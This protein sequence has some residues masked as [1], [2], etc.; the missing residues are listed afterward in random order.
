MDETVLLTRISQQLTFTT[1]TVNVTTGVHVFKWKYSKDFSVSYGDDG[2]F[3]RLVEVTGT[4]FADTA[5]TPCSAGAFANK[6]GS[7]TCSLCPGG[8]SS[9][10][11]GARQ[12]TPCR[13]NEYSFPGASRCYPSPPC[14]QADVI[15]YYSGCF[16]NQTRAQYYY[17]QTPQ[18]CSENL[19]GAYRKPADRY[20]L[21]CAPCAPGTQRNEQNGQ[22]ESCPTNTYS[23][24]NNQ[25]CEPCPTGHAGRRDF[26]WNN[27]D[28][29]PPASVPASMACTGDC[30]TN[31][32]RL[33]GK[34]YIDSGINHGAYALSSFSLD[35]NVVNDGYVQFNF[36]FAC[37]RLCYLGLVDQDITGSNA[38]DPVLITTMPLQSFLLH[39]G[40]HT[41]QLRIS[42]GSHRFSWVFS[43]YDGTYASL[44]DHVKIYSIQ[45][46]S[47]VPAQGGA[48]N[49]QAC[50]AGTFVT[51]NEPICQPTPPGTYSGPLA[52]QPVACPANTFAEHAGSEGCLPCGAGTTSA[53]GSSWCDE[54]CRFR[55]NDDISYDLKPLSRTGGDMYGPIAGSTNRR[56]YYLNVCSRDHSNAT[57]LDEDRKPLSTQS[58]VNDDLG[59]G[60]D[61]GR[62]TN[63]YPHPTKPDQ[64]LTIVYRNS[65][66]D[67]HS[68]CYPTGSGMFG[69][70]VPR[71]TNITFTCDSVA[72]YGAPQFVSSDG[73][74]TYF[75]WSTL[76][77][78]PACDDS[79]WDF[80][81]TECIDG[82]QMKTYKWKDNPRK[83]HSGQSLPPPEERTC[84]VDTQIPCPAGTYLL[85][86]CVACPNGTWSLG[87]AK[88]LNTWPHGAVPDASIF[89]IEPAGSNTYVT[90]EDTYLQIKLPYDA[91]ST[92]VSL[93]MTFNFVE[94]SGAEVRLSL[95][96]VAEHGYLAYLVVDEQ[97]SSILSTNPAA[98]EIRI[99][100]KTVGTHTIRLTLHKLSYVSS[101]SIGWIRIFKVYAIGTSKAASLCTDALPGTFVSSPAQEPENCPVNTYQPLARQTS[102]LAVPAGR[103]APPGS[104]AHYESLSCH[105]QDFQQVIKGGG[106]VTDGPDSQKGRM[107]VELRPIPGSRCHNPPNWPTEIS[108]PCA[109]PPGS[110]RG[111]NGLCQT[112]SE[113]RP[114]SST[115]NSCEAPTAGTAGYGTWSLLQGRTSLPPPVTPSNVKKNAVLAQIYTAM[116]NKEAATELFRADYT[117][118]IFNSLTLSENDKR[119]IS[120][121]ASS[122]R[123]AADAEADW[124]TV[125][126]GACQRPWTFSFFPEDRIIQTGSI[127][128]SGLSVGSSISVLSVTIPMSSSG[129]QLDVSYMK[130]GGRNTQFIILVDGVAVHSDKAD[131]S[132]PTLEFMLSGA[133][134]HEI[135]FVLVANEGTISNSVIR[136][137][138]LTVYGAGIGGRTLLSCPAG[139][140]SA[141]GSNAQCT[142]CAVGTAAES[143][144][145]AQCK[146]CEDGSFAAF[147]ASS[148]CSKCALDTSHPTSGA[149]HGLC[150]PLCTFTSK[151]GSEHYDWNDLL[152][153]AV[154]LTEG[155]VLGKFPELGVNPCAATST[156]YG[157]LGTIGMEN[158]AFICGNDPYA[159]T[160]TA[161]PSATRTLRSLDNYVNASSMDQVMSQTL[162][163]DGRV[164]QMNYGTSL[165]SVSRE[166]AGI[167]LLTY[168]DG[169][170]CPTGARRTTELKLKCPTATQTSQ[171]NPT[172]TYFDFCRVSM[173]WI[174]NS[175]CK[176]CTIDS[177]RKVLGECRSR[178]QSVIYV[179]KEGERCHH[180]SHIQPPSTTQP[181]SSIHISIGFV[182]AGVICLAL[183][184][185]SVAV[186][187]LRHKK[188]STEYRLLKA[189]HDGT[190][191]DNETQFGLEDDEDGVTLDR[192]EEDD[193][194][195]LRLPTAKTLDNPN[196]DL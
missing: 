191:A 96:N 66:S 22:C 100:I 58:C 184:V 144:R 133:P 182:V 165:K 9:E 87:G 176:A 161:S 151:D 11:P 193:D 21:A 12:C 145:S 74:T 126:H 118:E 78:C 52:T 55:L 128:E 3:L 36:A 103:W 98:H 156:R 164:A 101:T 43:K 194:D 2:A 181:C 14:Q 119:S 123:S 139:Y 41:R 195:G 152:P 15:T 92:P 4:S 1:F 99:P 104:K 53:A 91:F 158:Q 131:S 61:L 142:P 31:G 29:L 84:S 150:Q 8:T 140:Y 173:E 73:C 175:A 149:L 179:L 192:I 20:D 174:T 42:P 102:C 171:V 138:K 130:V 160:S 60:I 39:N 69:Q 30:G 186:F 112:C 44:N 59:F 187:C 135:L 169:D 159:Q 16:A 106:C 86:Q 125:C 153:A 188:L 33:S 64:G 48:P 170:V 13:A 147:A 93:T 85:D 90:M 63:F 57:C 67:E 196:E 105:Y 95:A 117:S 10:N 94:T 162:R 122:K 62:V 19:S 154:R 132:N 71:T 136:I 108:V 82:K 148:S 50:T 143:P 183:L 163:R 137:S 134:Q 65:S 124:Y 79:Y 47:V 111:S 157:C 190:F 49:C 127:I 81:Y 56:S 180:S 37:D 51:A 68:G 83:C 89:S 146:T 45:V 97:K 24:G 129:G 155:Q 34:G 172:I 141:G 166:S 116:D 35:L 114:Y 113:S 40:N 121:N 167:L 6:T 23:P 25:R 72:G 107:T 7:S 75:T 109:C 32:W 28:E 115:T 120:T 77:A 38:T 88:I 168:T 80:F 17:Y 26:I 27:F 177:Y 18:I 110:F 189:A 185:V 46:T 70:P 76:F 178:Q 54:S 5:C